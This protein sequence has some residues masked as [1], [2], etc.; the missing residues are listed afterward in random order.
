VKLYLLLHVTLTS[1]S[2]VSHLHFKLFIEVSDPLAHNKQTIWTLT[3]F[4]NYNMSEHLSLSHSLSLFSLSPSL[5]RTPSL[6]PSLSHP[7]FIILFLLLFHSHSLSLTLSLSLSLTHSLSL[8]LSLIFKF[9][10]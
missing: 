3:L 5:P 9:D 1:L 10:F 8:F 7:L 4:F 6:S 2:F